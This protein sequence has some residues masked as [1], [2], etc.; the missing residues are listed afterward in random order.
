MLDLD[1]HSTNNNKYTPNDPPPRPVARQHAQEVLDF[2]G[3]LFDPLET[4]S[5]F[6]QHL[7]LC[8]HLLPP[9][10]AKVPQAHLFSSFHHESTARVVMALF[11]GSTLYEGINQIGYM[12]D[13]NPKRMPPTPLPPIPS[14]PTN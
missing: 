9:R 13:W 5:E 6:L 3:S 1:I 2:A 11:N 14:S 8:S 10:P 12:G 7:C 4:Q